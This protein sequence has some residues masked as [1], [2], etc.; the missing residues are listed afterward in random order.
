MADCPLEANILLMAIYY[1][2]IYSLVYIVYYCLGF[3][4]GVM[5]V[6]VEKFIF[7]IN[8]LGGQ[9]GIFGMC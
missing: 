9:I 4:V 1:I 8:C 5:L 6:F 3:E 7:S 2:C